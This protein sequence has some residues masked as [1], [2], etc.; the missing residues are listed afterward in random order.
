MTQPLL[1][2]LSLRNF[3]SNENKFNTQWF[4]HNAAPYKSLKTVYNIRNFATILPISSAPIHSGFRMCK[5]QRIYIWTTGTCIQEKRS[6]LKC[7]D[8]ID[9]FQFRLFPFRR[10]C[11][12]AVIPKTQNRPT[13][14]ACCWWDGKG[15][16]SFWAAASEDVFSPSLQMSSYGSN[17]TAPPLKFYLKY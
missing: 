5:P 10:Q 9:V 2:D 15:T 8:K 3:R 11:S 16:W 4:W 17:C 6:K 12:S 13:L 14:S 7:M 1:E